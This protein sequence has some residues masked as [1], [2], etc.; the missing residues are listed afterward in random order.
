MASILTSIE[1]AMKSAIDGMTVAGGYN[2]AWNNVH[3]PDLAL[4]TFPNCIIMIEAERCVDESDGAACQ[5]YTQECDFLIVVR[6]Q[7]STV[8]DIPNYSVN[9]EHNK[10][11]DDLKKLF[12]TNYHITNNCD[13]IMYKGMERE[14]KKN[15]DIY[16]P[17]EMVTRWTVY[18]R[19]DRQS[20]EITG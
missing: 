20:P 9:A 10:A 11:L 12:G 6:G 7:L 15:G 18:Y 14:I 2:Y 4:A 3:Q 1:S 17:G 13:K 16:V 19:Q 5:L 8:T